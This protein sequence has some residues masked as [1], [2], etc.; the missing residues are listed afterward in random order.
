MKTVTLELPD[1]L[2]DLAGFKTEHLSQETL[3]LIVLELFREEVIS[4]GKAAE[5]CGLSIAEFMEFAASRRVPLHYGEQELQQDRE[6][7]KR[8]G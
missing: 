3:K 1:E 2:L 5:L 7:F 8:L 6:Q 4:L